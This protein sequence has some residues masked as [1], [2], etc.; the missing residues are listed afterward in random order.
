MRIS[1][2][3]MVLKMK[4]I[5]ALFLSA[6]MAVA[7][8]SAAYGITVCKHAPYGQA[9][10]PVLFGRITAADRTY[11]FAAAVVHTAGAQ[12]FGA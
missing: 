6:V 1:E 9:V 7:L 5:L 10:R 2:G 3:D 4:K 12:F 11:S 8:F